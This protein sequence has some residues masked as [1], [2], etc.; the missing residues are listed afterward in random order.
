MWAYAMGGF[1][2]YFAFDITVPYPEHLQDWI[3]C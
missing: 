2:T 1:G 3:L